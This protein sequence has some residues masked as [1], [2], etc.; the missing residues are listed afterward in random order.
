MPPM[1]RV[2]GYVRTSAVE[3]GPDLSAGLLGS[4]GFEV[5]DVV[6]AGVSSI[7]VHADLVFKRREPQSS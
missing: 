6:D 5:A 1:T 3:E 4:H 7:G 2:A